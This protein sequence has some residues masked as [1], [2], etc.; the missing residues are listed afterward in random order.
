M[1]RNRRII[2]VALVCIIV[3]L[4]A[5]KITI[6][7]PKPKELLSDFLEAN[8]PLTSRQY[9]LLKFGPAYFRS[10]TF[11]W[12]PAPQ[13]TEEQL[14]AQKQAGYIRKDDDFGT[15]QAYIIYV[16][17]MRRARVDKDVHQWLLDVEGKEIS[18]RSANS[19]A[20]SKE[21]SMEI[22]QDCLPLPKLP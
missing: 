12:L 8:K 20:E 5:Y 15:T 4:L 21:V 11:H 22:P 2:V 6:R 18:V 13:P 10:C 17:G 1:T 7:N 19:H 3:V 16:D 9:A 14:A